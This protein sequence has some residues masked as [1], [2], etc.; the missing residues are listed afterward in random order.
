MNRLKNL[1]LT[2]GLTVL[3]STSGSAEEAGSI[4]QDIKG[5]A[6]A[7]KREWKK[8]WR[9]TKKTAKEVGRGAADAT[10]KTARKVKQ[11]I[12]D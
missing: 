12:D 10:E 5:A 1:A 4:K 7:V 2:I 8:G 6:R 11:N 9:A 3:F